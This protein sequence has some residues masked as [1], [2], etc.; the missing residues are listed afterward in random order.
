MTLA[1]IK[2]KIVVYEDA[3]N[4]RQAKQEQHALDTETLALAVATEQASKDAWLTALRH[5]HAVEDE[6]EA[7]V[8]A[9]EPPTIPE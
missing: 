2:D 7:L 4:D 6:L 9:H 8:V 3:V 5:E 1:E